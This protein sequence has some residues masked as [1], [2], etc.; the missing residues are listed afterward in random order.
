MIGKYY[1]YLKVKVMHFP[2]KVFEII[3]ILDIH[4]PV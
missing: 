3:H 1:V 2:Y 4:I